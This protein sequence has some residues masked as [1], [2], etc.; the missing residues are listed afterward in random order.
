MTPR[1]AM[2]DGDPDTPVHVGREG[3]AL[4]IA[5]DRPE[6]RNA[7]NTAVAHALAAAF[8]RLDQDPDV[9]VGVLTGTGPGFCAGLDLRAF[10][11]GD[12]GG[13]PERGFAGLTRR[14]PEKPLIA[15]IEGFAIAGGFEIALACDLIV[16]AR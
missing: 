14:G 9:D 10:L 16:A 3:R 13:H 11:D 4:V 15:A 1:A 6:R 2:T 5:I 8:T 12:E 7:I